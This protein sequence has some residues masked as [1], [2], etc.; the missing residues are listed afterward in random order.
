[1]KESN[2]D[3]YDVIVIGAGLGGLTAAA[4]LAKAGKKVLLVE[5]EKW[6]GG[7]FGPLMHGDY[8]FNNGPRLL[9]GCN[10]DGPY[11][12]GVTY[13]LLEELGMQGE[14]E[15]I[16]LQPFTA[17]RMPGLEY[18]LWSGREAFIQGLESAHPGAFKNL[19]ELLDLCAKIQQAGIGY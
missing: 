4:F 18:Q 11:G 14:C 10:A 5:K 3:Q 9:M 13:S 16:P 15:F 1:M 12:P 7:Y 8:Y 2:E 17:V 19:P 6:V